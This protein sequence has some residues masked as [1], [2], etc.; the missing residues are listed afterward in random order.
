MNYEDGRDAILQNIEVAMLTYKLAMAGGSDD[1]KIKIN[2]M[3]ESC[4]DRDRVARMAAVISAC[5]AQ[6][7]SE[8][9]NIEADALTLLQDDMQY[10]IAAEKAFKGRLIMGERGQK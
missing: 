5:V 9:V 4:E 7:G 2:G 3:P 1:G 8:T 10:V 6:T